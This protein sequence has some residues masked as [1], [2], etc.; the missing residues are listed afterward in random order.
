MRERYAQLRA[1]DR[2]LEAILADGARRAHAI[3]APTLAEVRELMGVGS[4]TTAGGT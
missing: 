1:D 4:P 2:K 3:A